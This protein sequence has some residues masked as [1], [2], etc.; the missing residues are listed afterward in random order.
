MTDTTTRTP[1]PTATDAATEAGG[2][3]GPRPTGRPG[4]AP[5]WRWHFYASVLV[6]P[7]LLMLAVTGHLPVPV[8][9]EPLLH[10]DLMQVEQPADAE[11][12]SR[13]PPS[14]PPSS[15]STPTPGG[16]DDRTARRRT[17]HD[18]LRRRPD[19]RRPRRVRRPVRRRGARR[20]GPGHHAVRHARPA[21][22]RPDGRHRG[23]TACRARRLLG[24]R[25]GAD[26]LLPVLRG[27][28]ARRRRRRRAPGGRA[29]PPSRRGRRGRRRR[30]ALP[31]GLRP[32]LD[33]LLGRQGADAGHRP[34][35]LVWSTDHGALSDPTSTLDESLPH[36]HATSA[37]GA[38]ATRR[39]RPPG[40][41]RQGERRERRHRGRG[42][43]AGGPAAPDDRR[44]AGATTSGVFSAIGYAFDAPSDERTVHVDQY[45]GQV[46]AT[47]GF[48][49][50]PAARQ[51]G[52]AG[53]RPARGPPPRTV[54]F[55][56][57]AL[58]CLGDRL[59][60]ASPAR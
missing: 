12:H 57:S 40:P 47:Y 29:A 43:L 22:R 6:V 36:S 4:S 26:R 15:A 42:R 33:R 16:L 10:P 11:L 13:T 56:A 41:R 39:C 60:G 46:V 9:A 23:A 5:F 7:V 19:G 17:Q 3:G 20:A 52:L 30:A 50:Y 1:T 32:A 53:H 49:D 35:H 45:G 38:S 18:L 31:A 44:A 8:P 21:A 58:F 24:D 2:A 59:H 14:S 37:L 48:D 51:G 27:W 54:D 28:R 55:W 34:R 25:D